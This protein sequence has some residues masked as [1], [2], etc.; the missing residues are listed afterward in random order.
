MLYWRC[1]QDC[2][3]SPTESIL[4]LRCSPEFVDGLSEITLR[5]IGM[6]Y[7]HLMKT[8]FIVILGCLPLYAYRIGGVRLGEICKA[9]I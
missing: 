8:T 3:V 7:I 9:R 6:Y 1:A 2:C 4:G 5:Q